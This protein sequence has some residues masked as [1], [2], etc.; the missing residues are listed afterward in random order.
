MVQKAKGATEPVEATAIGLAH[1][2]VISSIGDAGTEIRRRSDQVLKH[3][4]EPAV[5]PHGYKALR[6]DQIAEPG[7]ITSQ[8]LQHVIEDPLVI[9]DLT[10]R[11]P[12][13]YYELAVRH[14]IRKPLVQIIKKGESLPFDVAGT[15]T[16][17]FDHQ[18]L[19]SVE[20]AK[21][22]IGRQIAS[23]AAR[24]GDVESPIFVSLDL[25]NLRQS[26][27]PEERSLGDILIMMTE[28]RAG[29]SSLEKRL[30][31]PSSLIPPAYIRDISR[32]RGRDREGQMMV[33]EM[34]A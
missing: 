13:V 2:F 1:C 24:P 11:N 6:A 29:M 14:A 34:S 10:D 8:V 22:E 5:Q 20:E 30:S 19:D 27:N 21:L 16:I 4:I 17:H 18:D 9:A 26:D 28:M 3:I 12:N 31:D 33:R 25:Q 7:M 32:M 23:L 15:R